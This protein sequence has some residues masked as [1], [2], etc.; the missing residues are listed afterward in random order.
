MTLF[1]L[2]AADAADDTCRSLQIPIKFE[3]LAERIQE[4]KLQKIEGVL[5][6]FPAEFR[7]RYVL[8]YSSRSLQGATPKYPRVI[9][10]GLDA[11]F[12]LAF[13]GHPDLDGYDLLETIQFDEANKKFQFR[14]ISFPKENTKSPA[15]SLPVI[16]EINPQKCMMCHREDLRP[17]WDTYAAWPGVYGSRDD[18]MPAA[19]IEKYQI[20]QDQI[21]QK[22]GRYRFFVSSANYPDPAAYDDYFNV[23]RPN[24]QFNILLSLLNSQ[25]IA[26]QIKEKPE[27]HSFRYAMLGALRCDADFGDP[28]TLSEWIPAEITARFSK[29]YQEIAADVNESIENSYAE[30]ETR[31][32]LI[33]QS[34][35]SQMS[36]SDWEHAFRRKEKPYADR[37]IRLRYILEG[38][39]FGFPKWSMEFGARNYVFFAGPVGQVGELGLYL[40][41]ELLDPRKDHEVYEI[42]LRAWKNRDYAGKMIFDD[43]TENLCKQLKKKSLSAFT[44]H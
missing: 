26:R 30:R 2:A 11:R 18:Q 31:Q 28:A 15:D 4:C 5:P 37:T 12:I 43:G 16:S 41:Q 32:L 14:S 6:L 10:F 1:F 7:S 9:M 42:Y 3:Q 36:I 13:A 40:W 44:S 8:V 29:S 38:A 35:K 25:S 27:L 22:E 21:F 39:N 34:L 19:E 20:F 33:L 24:L 23:G 17:N